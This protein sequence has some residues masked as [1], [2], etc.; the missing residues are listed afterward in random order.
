MAGFLSDGNERLR[1]VG[2]S[3]GGEYG[4]WLHTGRAEAVCS[5][6]LNSFRGRSSCELI[7]LALSPWKSLQ[8]S[9]EYTI[10]ES[11]FLCALANG[12]ARTVGECARK[13]LLFF[14]FRLS[15]E[16][17]RPIYVSLMGYAR[18]GRMPERDEERAA[19][20]IFKELG[21]FRPVAGL[22][23]VSSPKRR[24]CTES[25]LFMALSTR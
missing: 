14:P 2:F 20:L 4:R 7:C 15:E 23:P 3:Q 5:L 8:S 18:E 24:S 9:R 1:L 17:L 12:D 6:Q 10:I 16:A 21:F 25:Q 22:E 13:L 19:A 11:A